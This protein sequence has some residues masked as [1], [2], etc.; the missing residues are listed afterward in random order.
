MQNDRMNYVVRRY[1]FTAADDID[2]PLQHYR[3]IFFTDTGEQRGEE[4]RAN[5]ELRSKER[6]KIMN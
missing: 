2:E 1:K 6:R 4:E 5:D 3:I